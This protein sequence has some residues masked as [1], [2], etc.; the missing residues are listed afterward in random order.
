MRRTQAQ[1]RTKSLKL[2]GRVALIGRDL[3]IDQEKDGRHME[4]SLFAEASERGLVGKI[5]RYRKKSDAGGMSIAGVLRR[6]EEG[7]VCVGVHVL[8]NYLRSD[9]T[10]N[11]DL[12]I[13]ISEEPGA[14]GTFAPLEMEQIAF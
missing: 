13:N 11:F 4:R 3:V 5:V 10:G 6:D 9:F 7:R 2:K 12:K 8:E 14:P 1:Q